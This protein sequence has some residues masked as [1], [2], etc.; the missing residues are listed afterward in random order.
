L[1]TTHSFEAEI[2]SVRRILSL[3]AVCMLATPALTG[4]RQAASADEGPQPPAGEAWFT[5]DQMRAAQIEVS[6]ARDY[7]VDEVVTTSGRVTFDDLKVAHIYSP[8]TGRVAKMTASLG[9]RL[10]R[11]APLASIA[12]PDIGQ[13]SSD[14]GKANADLIAAEH[15]FKRKSDLLAVKA[16][17]QADYEASEDAYRQAKAEKE[18]AFLKTQLLRGGTSDAVNQSFTLTTPIDGEVIARMVSPG[19]EVQG[20]YAN[21]NAVELFTVGELD[22]VWVLA[23]IYESD[24]ARVRVGAKV[25]VSAVA[26]PGKTF[27]GKLDWVSGTLDPVTR[28]AKVRCAFDNTDRLLKPEMYANVRIVASEAR[29]ALAVP[30][31]AVVRLGE[32][33]VVFAQEGQSPDG[34]VRFERL[35]VAVDDAIEGSF[36]PIEHGVQPGVQIVTRG[37]QA[38]SSAM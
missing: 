19:V 31:S 29:Q 30:R 11:G 32:Q 8:V 12:S 7:P 14:L 22:T 4:C 18:R 3:A 33:T 5:A 28:T 17:A 13:W 6:P 24:L 16:V 38:V 34:R 9:E 15:D 36:V 37:A 1:V 20:Q 27:E 25:T 23:D 10:K 2:M 35:P 26:Y 21:G